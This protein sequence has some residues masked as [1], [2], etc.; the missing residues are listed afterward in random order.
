VV[1]N[2]NSTVIGKYPASTTIKGVTP[3]VSK[4]SNLVGKCI[5]N[6]DTQD[7]GMPWGKKMAGVLIV[8]GDSSGLMNNTSFTISNMSRSF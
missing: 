3:N 8:V 4:L 5:L 1:L 2:Q 7:N 6:A